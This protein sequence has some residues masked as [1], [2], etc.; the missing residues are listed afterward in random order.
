MDCVRIPKLDLA[1]PLAMRVSQAFILQDTL[2]G[3]P[4][5]MS[6]SIL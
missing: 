1:F 5:A 3:R 6:E 4:L 2:L